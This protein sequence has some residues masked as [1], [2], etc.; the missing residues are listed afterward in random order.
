MNYIRH[1]CIAGAL[2]LTPVMSG[3]ATH[4]TGNVQDALLYADGTVNIRTSWR[5]DFTVLCNTN[6]TH[7]NVPAEVCL[8]WYAI[9]AKAAADNAFLTVYYAENLTCAALPTYAAS[10]V[11]IYVGVTRQ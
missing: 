10:P 4:C 6:G 7:G 3:A 8:S 1:M 5:G 2:M 9:A 11:P